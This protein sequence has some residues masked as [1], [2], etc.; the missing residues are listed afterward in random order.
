MYQT[1]FETHHLGYASAIAWVLFLVII[2]VA[3]ANFLLTRRL[4]STGEV[5]R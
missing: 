2:I 1:A 5:D 4:A 3:V